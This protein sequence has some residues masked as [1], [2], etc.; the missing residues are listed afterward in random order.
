MPARPNKN[1]GSG[2]VNNPVIKLSF[3]NIIR[4]VKVTLTFEDNKRC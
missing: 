2:S 3:E 1:L 4:P